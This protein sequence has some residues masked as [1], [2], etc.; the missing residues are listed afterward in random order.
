MFAVRAR[1]TPL[2]AR[3][4]ATAAAETK[5]AATDKAYKVVV[6]GGGPGG[7]SGKFSY[8]PFIFKGTWEKS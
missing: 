7:L 6:V 1:L 4:F 8:T 3:G 2:Y 5:K